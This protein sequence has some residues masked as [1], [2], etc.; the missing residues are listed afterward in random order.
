MLREVL[1]ALVVAL[2]VAACDSQDTF[3]C[4]NESN[5]CTIGQDYC[6]AVHEIDMTFAEMCQQLPPTC[7][8]APTCDCIEASL[9]TLA[10][11][12]GRG[13][14]SCTEFTST[15]EPLFAVECKP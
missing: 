7:A 1:V 3:F 8:A 13:S 15:G 11:C 14:Y 6:L 10:V 4:G 5:V 2:A 12:D 9:P